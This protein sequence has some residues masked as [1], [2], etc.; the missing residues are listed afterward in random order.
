MGKEQRP[1]LKFRFFGETL[2]LNPVLRVPYLAATQ[3]ND[4]RTPKE[5]SV[6]DNIYLPTVMKNGD[7]IA[8][9]LVLRVPYLAATRFNDRRTP[10]EISVLDNIY[11]PTVMKN[12][13]RIADQDSE[14]MRRHDLPTITEAYRTMVRENQAQR[15][16]EGSREVQAAPRFER[17]LLDEDM[18]FEEPEEHISGPVL[19][20]A[21]I[22]NQSSKRPR[23]LSWVENLLSRRTPRTEILH[24]ATPNQ[25][26]QRRDAVQNANGHDVRFGH[27]LWDTVQTVRSDDARFGNEG[28]RSLR[29][30]DLENEGEEGE[31]EEEEGEG[32]V[33]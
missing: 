26:Q 12:G 33:E 4:R 21:N 22:R 3:F 19:P 13:D 14:E 31:M 29:S 32:E 8:E 6:L 24:S 17:R 25:P 27:E 23:L 7:R 28:Y 5:I 30:S 1:L 16:A 9:N 11:L 20:T 2:C 10:E 18:R 15:S